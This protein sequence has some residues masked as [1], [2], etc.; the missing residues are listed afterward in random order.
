MY[1][2]PIEEL[3]CWDVYD[4]G[5]VVVVA[6]SLSEQEMHQGRPL[7]SLFLSLSIIF[8][9]GRS[10]ILSLSLVYVHR[11]LFF[12]VYSIFID[13]LNTAD[14]RASEEG[15]YHNTYIS[16]P[17]RALALYSF[18]SMQA[19]TAACRVQ[20]LAAVWQLHLMK[21]KDDEKDRETMKNAKN[22]SLALLFFIIRL[23]RACR[24]LLQGMWYMLCTIMMWNRHKRSLGVVID[25]VCYTGWTKAP[26][27]RPHMSHEVFI[28]RKKKKDLT[29]FLC[30]FDYM[31]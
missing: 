15:A 19:K 16:R 1:M 22:F 12:L 13:S 17:G 25:C 5:V 11:F 18:L 7:F 9:N 28:I 3:S 14:C 29:S 6:H 31:V 2:S 27:Y 20:W 21:E 23:P 4:D 30:L 24:S 10:L 8:Y 26:G